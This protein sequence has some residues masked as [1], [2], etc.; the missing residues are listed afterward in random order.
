METEP[1]VKV[2][3]FSPATHDLEEEE[4]VIEWASA[5]LTLLSQTSLSGDTGFEKKSLIIKARK[6]S[7]RETDVMFK[8]KVSCS[9]DASFKTG[10]KWE[11]CY[12]CYWK[13]KVLVAPLCL[14]LCEP[15]DCSPP[16]SSVPGIWI[17]YV[18]HLLQLG[19]NTKHCCILKV[20]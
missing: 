2:I 11:A 17:K 8:W 5:I 1:M 10:E 20:V 3:S 12:G 4:R 19:K 7:S 15:M 13:V 6:G 14:N 18:V 16:D 9:H